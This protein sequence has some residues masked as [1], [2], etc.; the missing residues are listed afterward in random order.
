MAHEFKV[1]NGLIVAGDT[2]ASGSVNVNNNLNVTQ[3]LTVS[4]SISSPTF[5]S[6][7]AGS[8]YRLD[9]GVT[10][11]GHTSLT[12]DSLTVRDKMN[13]YELN[14]NQI[15][16]TNG[17]VWV[18][19]SGK[20]DSVIVVGSAVTMSFDTGSS[21]NGVGHGFKVNDLIRA[22]RWDANNTSS[23]RSDI[24]VNTVINAQR[25]Y[26]TILSST[27]PPTASF[28]Y[29][30]VGNTTDTTR[31][32]AI[33]LTSADSNAPYIDVIDNISST[34]SL[35][36]AGTVKTR[37]GKLS[38]VTSTYFGALSGYGLWASGSVYLEGAINATS[39]KVADLTIS[40]S[41]LYT[42]TGTFNN[43]NTPFYVSASNLSL[44]NKLSWDGTTLN[45]NGVFTASAGRIGGFNTNAD[46]LSGTGFYISG[47]ATGNGYFISSSNMNIKANGDISAS[48]VLITGGTISGSSLTINVS[49]L[50]AKGNTVDI[51]GSNFRL[52]N[53]NITASNA[54][55]A[56]N[57]TATTLTATGSGVI[58]G[59]TLTSTAI[60]SSNNQLVLKSNGQITASNA[61]F[62]G[63]IVITG[64]IKAVAGNIGGFNITTTDISSS[65]NALILRSNGQI[66]GSSVL[67]TG[68]KVGGF[69]LSA[70]AISGNGFY[71]SGSATS[72]N[73][74]ISASNFNVKANGN[75]TASN[76]LL[77]N[78]TASSGFFT[79][80]ITSQATMSG[81]RVIGAVVKTNSTTGSRAELSGSGLYI[82]DGANGLVGSIDAPL[83]DGILYINGESDSSIKFGGGG[84]TSFD[85]INSD[86]IQAYLPL[87]VNGY[88]MT[89]GYGLKVGYETTAS[90]GSYG[91]Q[92]GQGVDTNLYRSKA[93]TLKTDDS[94]Q[95]GVNL[96][97]TGSIT[98]TN[99]TASGNIK[100]TGNLLDADG[101]AV[102]GR[103][104]GARDTGVAG[105]ELNGYTFKNGDMYYETTTG[106]DGQYGNYLDGLKIYV[107]S[108]VGWRNI[109]TT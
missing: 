37:L 65:G 53:G 91:I 9:N 29:V 56:G 92:F 3:S 44:G 18:S 50:T 109:T 105:Q 58:G 62:S 21:V 96:L 8:G 104:L 25:L 41:K 48:G 7:F 102:Y 30:R 39:G 57:L 1:K 106:A 77:Q 54:V 28:E 49:N 31:Q 71:I 95:V 107:N 55:L 5:I 13:V 74:F 88:D 47:S 33:Y 38:G 80:N 89:V 51:S 6:G 36:T 70:D 42:G 85:I 76:A 90:G 23:M 69:T 97:V 17:S 16:A 100:V 4:Q 60:S 101:T 86:S 67:F 103:W 40:S 82:Y 93:D 75:L 94:F 66:T 32:G 24:Q 26:G 27:T 61:F 108:T 2:L 15:S 83:P 34:A 78:V 81:G 11:T 43:S 35:N 73:Y 63:S 79:G 52:L 98:T 72:S 19:D 22:Q 12:V 20:V 59:F 87:Q 84:Q 64:S 10:D 99:V 46:A 68:G 14:I 45:I